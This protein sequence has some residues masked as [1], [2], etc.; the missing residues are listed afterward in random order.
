MLF[1][2]CDDDEHV[3]IHIYDFTSGRFAELK[4]SW[5][6][7]VKIFRYIS[8]ITMIYQKL[9]LYATTYL[10]WYQIIKIVESTHI[11]FN[12]DY[13]GENKKKWSKKKCTA[14]V[15][16]PKI[17]ACH[18]VI[19]GTMFTFLFNLCLRYD[20]DYTSMYAHGDAIIVS[21][22]NTSYVTEEPIG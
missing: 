1:V 13:V 10:N 19:N 14:A 3:F 11:Y 22:G 21:N 9:L 16:S 18:W 6:Y 8:A 17:S 20:L 2:N 5:F 4:D 12:W 7:L 15:I